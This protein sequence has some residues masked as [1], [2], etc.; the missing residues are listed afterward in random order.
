M[1]Y[2]CEQDAR[3]VGPIHFPESVYSEGSVES[4]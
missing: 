2:W 3:S 1:K 4:V